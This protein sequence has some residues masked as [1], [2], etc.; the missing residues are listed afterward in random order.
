MKKDDIFLITGVTKEISKGLGEHI[1]NYLDMFE[2]T[3]IIPESLIP[4]KEDL[5]KRI[6]RAKE[7]IKR[8]KS[9]DASLFKI[10]D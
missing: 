8:L 10:I 6:K 3:M 7:L 2:S 1:E 5:E 4:S 9:G